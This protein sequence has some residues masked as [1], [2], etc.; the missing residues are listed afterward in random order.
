[1]DDASCAFVDFD[2]DGDGVS[3]SSFARSTCAF[4]RTYFRLSGNGSLGLESH[5]SV[6]GGL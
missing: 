3:A 6:N 2:S 4:R 1:M 5:G